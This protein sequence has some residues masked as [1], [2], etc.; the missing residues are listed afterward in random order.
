MD[1]QKIMLH[2]GAGHPD[3]GAP[4]PCA[5]R[6]PDWKEVRLDVDPANEPDVLASMLDMSPIAD[7]SIDAIYSAH[8]IEHLYPSEI[9]V[10]MEEM[11]RVLKPDGIVVT[12]CP[13]L[14][15]AARMIADDRLFDTAY[16][17]TCGPVT[18][19]DIVFSHRLFTGRDKPFMAHHSGFTVSTLGRTYREA[20][21]AG[22][23]G[24]RDFTGFQLFMLATRSEVP[25][26]DLRRLAERVLVW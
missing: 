11:L 20:G 23:V 18:P 17:A 19:F 5:F 1:N 12:V 2:I 14:Q 10:A 15:A 22:V 7:G 24:V 3:M 26:P 4:I 21:F 8:T 6:S 13:D 16:T 9:P 25:E